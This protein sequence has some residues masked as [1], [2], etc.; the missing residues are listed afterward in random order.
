MWE[1]KTEWLVGILV[2][3]L[4]AFLAGGDYLPVGNTNTE[5]PKISVVVD[6]GHGGVDPGK[7]GVNDAKEKEINLAI[8]KFLREA[9]EDRGVS[10]VMTRETDD[11][12]YGQYASNK[13]REDM[14]KRCAVIK[15]AGTAIAVSIHQNSYHQGGESGC[16][17][18]YYEGSK[19]GERLAACIQKTMTERLNPPKERQAKPN[20]SYYML[21]HTTAPTVIVECGFLS[22]WEEAQR[23]VTEDYQ[24]QVAD[25]VCAGIMEYLKEE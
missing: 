24:K 23:L 22:N 5:A 3:V 15:D 18:F 1:K 2:L 11:G 12:L 25:A 8:A 6:A 19:E 10:V 20:D 4:V 17:V 13:K 16:Q 7:I 9:L 14:Q 21:R